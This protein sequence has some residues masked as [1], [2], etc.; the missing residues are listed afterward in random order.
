[1]HNSK[2]ITNYKLLKREEIYSI[3]KK[4]DLNSQKPLSSY[5]EDVFSQI[6]RFSQTEIIIDCFCGIGESTYHLAKKYP[7]QLVIGFDKSLNRLEK[8]NSFKDGLQ[9]NVLLLQADVY[10]FYQV[11]EQI[12]KETGKKIV[13]QFIFYP[14][15][16][17]K[18][19]N[20]KKRVYLNNVIPYIFAQ[21]ST[22]EIRSNWGRFLVEFSYVAEFYQFDF[23]FEQL[24]IKTPLTP[25]E[26]KYYLSAQNLNRLL[27]KPL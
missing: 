23:R 10:D 21:E 26:K 22:V 1:M 5:C 7:D 8:Q 24:N 9:K 16:W 18:K 27:L 19:K 20:C 3:L 15:P 13:K 11:I 17:P 2:R 14:N 12:K 25:F 6:C 4:Y